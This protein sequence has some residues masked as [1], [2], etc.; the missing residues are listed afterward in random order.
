MA[1][2]LGTQ[3]DRRP[4][5]GVLVDGYLLATGTALD[6]ATGRVPDDITSLTDEVARCFAALDVALSEA[7]M[8]RADLVKTTCWLADEADRAEFIPAYR[9]QCAAGVYP[10]R[11]TM[12][13][14]L[15]G[16]AR[17]AIEAVAYRA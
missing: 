11:C 10:A 7:G 15:P 8:S 1:T 14:G 5:V 6:P 16:G 2:F 4:A 3:H 13:A 17:V 12:V 9:D